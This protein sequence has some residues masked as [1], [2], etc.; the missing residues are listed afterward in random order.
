L[1]E[2]NINYIFYEELLNP[3]VAEILAKETGAKLLMLHGAHNLTKE[4]FERNV[5]F[6]SLME[7]NLKNFIKGL[8][9]K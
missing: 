6:I 1:K 3:K 5:D 4:D 7:Q 2:H 8:E 9:C